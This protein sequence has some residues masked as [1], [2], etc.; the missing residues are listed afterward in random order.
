MT[1]HDLI[2]QLQELIDSGTDPD[3]EVRVAMQPSW[4]MEYRLTQQ[5]IATD[6]PIDQPVYLV[7][8]EQVGY[9]PETLSDA[10]GW[11]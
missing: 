7:E 11:R 4:P 6:G 8:Y 1:I 2:T 3:T 9:L 5:I 10:L